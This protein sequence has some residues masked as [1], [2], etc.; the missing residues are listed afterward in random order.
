MVEG[1]PGNF[2]FIDQIKLIIANLLQSQ[3]VGR[4]TEESAELIDMIGV[5]VDG[6]AGEVA[7]AHI[8]G[9]ALDVSVA[10]SCQGS[11]AWNLHRVVG[12][13]TRLTLSRQSTLKDAYYVRARWAEQEKNWR[14]DK[15]SECQTVT[16]RKD[17]P[18]DV[19][20]PKSIDTCLR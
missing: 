16:A 10:A 5:G 4:L 3:P 1:T 20:Q 11:H 8:F 14:K 17:P 15:P 2:L 9:H 12:V 7:D 18:I 13:A 6:A 19:T